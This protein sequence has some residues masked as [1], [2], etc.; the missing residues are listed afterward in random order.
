[1]AEVTVSSKFQLVIPREVREETGIKVGEKMVVIVKD[2]I[3]NLIP[4]RRLADLRGF[5]KG[6]SRGGLREDEDRV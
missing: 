4:Q 1:M 2:G 3:I 5:V 6:M